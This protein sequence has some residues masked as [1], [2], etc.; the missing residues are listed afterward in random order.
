MMKD[1]VAGIIIDM[2]KVHLWVFLQSV[3]NLL[4]FFEEEVLFLHLILFGTF[5]R[6]KVEKILNIIPKIEGMVIQKTYTDTLLD[7]SSLPHQ[8]YL[9]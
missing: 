5:P 8:P 9:A 2:N 7:I 4:F 6:H 1:S 3:K